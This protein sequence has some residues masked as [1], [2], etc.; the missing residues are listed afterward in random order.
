MSMTPAAP[1]KR[2]ARRLAAAAATLCL[3][4]ASQASQTIPVEGT[5]GNAVGCEYFR[6]S[7]W[8]DSD[9]FFQIEPEAL[10]TPSATCKF[11]RFEK[12]T[13]DEIAGPVICTMDPQND[14]P[15][16]QYVTRARIVR[17]GQNYIV[18]F[19]DGTSWGP[20]AKC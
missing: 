1:G 16:R 13:P 12:N 11:A 20:L 8:P 2:S 17:S 18:T 7:D 15:I 14:V 19:S 3:A 4:G 9:A 10:Q 6:T 5:Y